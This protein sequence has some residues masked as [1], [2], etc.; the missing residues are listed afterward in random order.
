MTDYPFRFT[1]IFDLNHRA[2]CGDNSNE[3][4]MK[5]TSHFIEK[6]VKIYLQVIIQSDTKIFSEIDWLKSQNKTK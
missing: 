4:L 2:N 6:K 1:K 5:N 3:K